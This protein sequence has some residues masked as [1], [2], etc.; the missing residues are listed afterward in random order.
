MLGS[1]N[2]AG[3]SPVPAERDLG[4][5]GIA[6][7]ASGTEAA[8]AAEALLRRRYRWA[9]EADAE[10]LVALGGDGFMLQTLHAML[11]DGDA[12]PVF[13][14][15]RGTVGFLMNEWRLDR[16]AERI[17]GAKHIK[18]APLQM[19]ATTIRGETWTHPAINEVSLLRE[20]R[21]TAKIE[22]SVDGRVVMPELVADGVLVATPAG[23]TAYNLSAHGPILPLAAKMLALTPIS[24]FR[25]RRWS[26]AI[27]P[28]DVA[29]NFRILEAEKRPVAAVADQFEVRDVTEVAVTLDKSRSLTLL[30]DPEH[31]LDERIAMEQFAT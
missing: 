2:I 6:L 13:G 14:M 4:Q 23:S 10:V 28:D 21:Q 29:V 26:G 11:E 24:P 8:L 17:E 3:Q 31:A 27:L 30:F 18:V 19:E 25:P 12:R 5:R 9:D 1:V 20:A 22:I 7:V 16:L 15:N